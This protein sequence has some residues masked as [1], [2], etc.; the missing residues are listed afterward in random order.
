MQQCTLG[1]DLDLEPAVLFKSSGDLNQEQYYIVG[2]PWDLC[3]VNISEDQFTVATL[4]RRVLK[5][6]PAMHETR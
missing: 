4:A 2:Y 1:V 3:A 5:K 6:V